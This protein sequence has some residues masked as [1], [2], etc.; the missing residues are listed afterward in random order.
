MCWGHVTGV[1]EENTRTFTDNWT[2]TGTIENAGDA[3]RLALDAGE[4]MI[5][6]TVN[7]GTFTIQLL[8]NEYAAGDTVTL[9]YRTGA[10]QA[11]CEAADWTEYAAPFD[12]LGFVQVRV[13]G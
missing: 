9:K 3:E 10:D 8:Q 2:G 7:T 1:L 11:A 4:Y 12:S 5:S 13:D 6:E